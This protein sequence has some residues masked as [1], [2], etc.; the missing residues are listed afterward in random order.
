MK[1]EI[2]L[3]VAALAVL[4]TASASEQLLSVIVAAK[5]DTKPFARRLPGLFDRLE[6]RADNS[7]DDTPPAPD[8]P[9]AEVP[10]WDKDNIAAQPEAYAK[11]TKGHFATCLLKATDEEAGKAW[12][13][14]YK[15][16][17]K[18]AH[19]PFRPTQR[20]SWGI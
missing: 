14:P 3:L 8:P 9:L 2:L 19:S 10:G 6:I 5:N 4:A 11:S 13:D 17:P 18:S 7:P 15:R 16:T 12:P 20:K 1:L